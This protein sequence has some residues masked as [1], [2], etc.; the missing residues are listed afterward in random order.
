MPRRA[1]LVCAGAVTVLGLF[2]STSAQPA[3]TRGTLW[4]TPENHLACADDKSF[5]LGEHVLLTGSGFDPSQ[6]VAITLEQGDD[7]IPVVTAK[8]NASGSL[9]V[10]AAIP[11]TAKATM[12]GEAITRFRAMPEGG[13]ESGLVL[14][15]AMLRI[16]T[17]GDTDGDGVRDI[18]DNCPHAAN[19]TQA[20]DDGDG[21]GDAC[22]K[23]PHDA[24]NDADGDGICGDVDPDPYTPAKP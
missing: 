11:A 7:V 4:V 22:D 16:F 19:P 13:D 15:S 23:C 21:I 14:S 3:R 2:V 1:A 17:D 10:S 12:D 5:T 24:E 9:S 8:A 6:S 20:D 18:C